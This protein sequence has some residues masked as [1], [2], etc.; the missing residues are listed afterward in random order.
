MLTTVMCIWYV[1]TRSGELQLRLLVLSF[2]L[3]SICC[4]CLFCF[5][6]V[7]RAYPSVPEKN[8]QSKGGMF[9]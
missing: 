2:L 4:L 9:N 5:I 7:N 3:L 6:F 8:Y 1:I